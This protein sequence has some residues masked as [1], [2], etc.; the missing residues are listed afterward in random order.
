MGGAAAGVIK[1]AFA[2][3]KG[4]VDGVAHIAGVSVFLPVVL[5]PADG[6]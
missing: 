2:Q 1:A 4:S 6:A 5:P 3:A